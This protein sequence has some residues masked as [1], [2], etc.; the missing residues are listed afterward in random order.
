MNIDPVEVIFLERT[1]GSKVGSSFPKYYKYRYDKN[2]KKL[3]EKALRKNYLTESDYEFNMYQATNAELKDV[4]RKYDLKVS[5]VKNELVDR[6]LSNVDEKDLKSI[7]TD[8][9]YKLTDSGKE[10]IN[11]NEHLIY[12]HKNQ[13]LY[14][15]SLEDYNKAFKENEDL[16]KYE[17][18]LEIIEN[19]ALKNRAEGDWGLYRNSF[20]SM[21]DVYI[22]MDNNEKA[23]ECLLK[24]C[25]IDL[26]GLSNNNGYTPSIIILAPG[27]LRKVNNVISNLDYT[28]SDLEDLYFPLAEKLDL[29]KER[30]SKEQSFEYII[31]AMNVGVDEVNEKIE[32]ENKDL[33][34]QIIDNDF[35]GNKRDTNK[36]TNNDNEGVFSLL[37][38]KFFK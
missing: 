23:L 25:H 15:I 8:S 7:F 32:E 31:E 38:K 6:L 24:V 36:S 27:I 12:Y 30:Y 34:S 2:P 21:A 4:L 16:N 28:E 11:S 1:E 33:S 26:S 35:S 10:I 13:K 37:I 5:G 3:L 9:Y 14:G 18:A 17:V 22:D 29:P 20:L 19:N